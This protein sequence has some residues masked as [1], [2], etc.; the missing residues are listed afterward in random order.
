MKRLSKFV[1]AAAMAGLVAVPVPQVNPGQGSVNI[2]PSDGQRKDTAP[3]PANRAQLSTF[4]L[5]EM[6]GDGMNS[7]IRLAPIW[8][9]NRPQ[10][11]WRK[12][13]SRRRHNERARRTRRNAA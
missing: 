9:H 4:S 3:A 1:M 7:G 5:R 12:V 11:G 10:P 8:P 13:Q 2:R 6:I